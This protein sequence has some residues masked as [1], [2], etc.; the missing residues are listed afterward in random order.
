MRDWRF[1]L[2]SAC[3]MCDLAFMRMDFRMRSAWGLVW[4]SVMFTLCFTAAV[5]LYRLD[6]AKG[7]DCED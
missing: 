3:A 6:K 4:D 1:W 5:I 2:M 7:D